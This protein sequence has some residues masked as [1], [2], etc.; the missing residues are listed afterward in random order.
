MDG[1]FQKTTNLTYGQILASC[2]NS[3]FSGCSDSADVL[4][5]GD[6]VSGYY[7]SLNSPS[8]IENKAAAAKS[9]GGIMIGELGQ[10]DANAPLFAEVAEAFPKSTS[11][12]GF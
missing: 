2:A 10:D 5:S 7:V 12:S 8:T 11:D 9:Y 3:T 6:E 4:T 1:T